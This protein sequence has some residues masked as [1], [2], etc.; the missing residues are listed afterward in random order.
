MNTDLPAPV[1][2]ERPLAP[3]AE[4]GLAE[5]RRDERGAIMVMG[6]FMAVLLVGALHYVMGLGETIMYRERMQDAADAGAFVAAVMHAR[7]MNLIALLNMA[8][9]SVIAVL[10][11]MKLIQAILFAAATAASGICLGCLLGGAGCWACPLVGP[12]WNGYRTWSNIV[13][14][15]E[16]VVER[17]VVALDGAQTAVAR[18]MPLAAQWKVVE[19]GTSTYNRPTQLGA[20]WPLLGTLPVEQDDSELLCEKAGQQAGRLITSPLAAIPAMRPFSYLIGRLVGRLA[21]TFASFFCGDERHRADRIKSGA[22]LG[23]ENFQVRAFMAGE[24]PYESAEQGVRLAAWGRD[25][26]A[27][28]DVRLMR[29]LGRLSFAQAEFYY[30]D[31]TEA[32]D[33]DPEEWMWHMNWRARLRRFRMPSSGAGMGL[34]CPPCAALTGIDLNEVVV[35]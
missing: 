19:T 31:G 20:M 35:H 3:D 6:V 14:R 11:A 24:P 8:M 32:S 28:M 18:G 25:E 7:G 26:Q 16:P 29:E 13:D 15:V 27:G 2:P 23:D 17:L 5:L 12:L 9:A 4:D 21:R 10:V 34:D 33:E 22:R 1:A 30:D